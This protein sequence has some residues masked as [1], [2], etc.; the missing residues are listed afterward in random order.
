MREFQCNW[1][2]YYFFL[3]KKRKIK[4]QLATT[5]IRFSILLCGVFFFFF[6]FSQLTHVHTV[7]YCCCIRGSDDN[8]NPKN[9][10]HSFSFLSSVELIAFLFV[11]F[12]SFFFSY[13]CWSPLIGT[14]FDFVRG[15]IYSLYKFYCHRLLQ[16]PIISF[17]FHN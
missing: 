5:N 15:S 3:N 16:L 11:K 1:F 2:S 4:S 7:Y 14:C 12:S 13:F 10:A 9:K 8:N 17:G 6:F